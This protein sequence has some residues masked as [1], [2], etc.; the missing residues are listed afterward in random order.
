MNKVQ[1]EGRKVLKRV[2]HIGIAVRDLDQSLRTYERLFGARADHF[3]E[4]KEYG[5]RI[6]FVPVGEVM[7]EMLAP[8]GLVKGRLSEFLEKHG[9]G[10]YH[11]AYRVDNIDGV[12]ADMKKNG[13]KLRDEKPRAGA[14]GARIAFISPEETNN[15]LT[16]LV[17]KPGSD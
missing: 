14:H 2:D 6:A 8:M 17:E 10:L 1:T 9:E 5:I 16:E 4:I 11:V 12:L 15:V 7:L 13:V 3:E